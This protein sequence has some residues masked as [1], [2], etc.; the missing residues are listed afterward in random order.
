MDQI[1]TKDE[2]KEF[3]PKPVQ[4]KFASLY[5]DTGN[6][7]TQGEMAKILGITR[8]TIYTWLLKPGFKKWLNTKRNEMI[9]DALIPIIKASIRKAK[10]GN[11]HHA[12][13]LLEIGGVYKPGM[14]IDTGET[15]LIR[16]EVVQGLAQIQ[17]KEG[18]KI[19]DNKSDT[20][21]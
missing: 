9:E 7:L 15:E 5:L 18:D 11:Y 16:I 12:R 13:L 10:A 3:I 4:V 14:K 2:V 6:I 20:N 17:Q 19:E 8:R 21:T 1:E